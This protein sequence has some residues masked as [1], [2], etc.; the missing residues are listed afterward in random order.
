LKTAFKLLAGGD[1]SGSRMIDM[2]KLPAAAIPPSNAE[3]DLSPS[4][5]PQLS[6]TQQ[7]AFSYK[8]LSPRNILD[9]EIYASCPELAFSSLGV[10]FRLTSEPHS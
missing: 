5:H 10:P 3:H 8:Y 2:T 6:N 4:E 9:H 7:N 1:A